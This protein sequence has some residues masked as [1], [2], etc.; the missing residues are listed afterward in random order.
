MKVCKNA[1][2]RNGLRK[3]ISVL[4]CAVLCCASVP[5]AMATNEAAQDVYTVQEVRFC[6]QNGEL[7]VA[8]RIRLGERPASV[9]AYIVL[10]TEVRMPSESNYLYP[11]DEYG[12]FAFPAAVASE[13]G[14]ITSRYDLYVVD[15]EFPPPN[16]YNEIRLNSAS[17]T[18]FDLSGRDMAQIT[19]EAIELSAYMSDRQPPTG[20]PEATETP[21]VEVTEAPTAEATETPV[22]EVTEAPTAEATEAP[23]A[24]PTE[25]PTAVPTEAPTAVP[26][27]APTAEPTEAPTAVPTE[28]PTAEPTE[29]PT[30]VSTEAPTAVPTEAPTAEPTEAPT[31]EPTEAPTAEPTEEPAPT[32]VP[33]LEDEALGYV[34]QLVEAELNAADTGASGS[35]IDDLLVGWVLH[36]ARV[37]RTDAG[38]QAVML[39]PDFAGSKATLPV[40]ASEDALPFLQ[41]WQG[42][43][44]EAA[45]AMELGSEALTLE[46]PAA[47]EWSDEDR[48]KV[49]TWLWEN[50]GASQWL[51]AEMQA[52]GAYSA[53]SNILFPLPQAELWQVD[54]FVDATQAPRHAEKVPVKEEKYRRFMRGASGE[55][56][57]RAQEA[58]ARQGYY[59]GEIDGKFTSE[60]EKAVKQY[61]KDNDMKAD[62]I[63]NA[64]FQRVLY[65]KDQMI[66]TSLTV[67]DLLKANG[68]AQADLDTWWSV[69]L[70]TLYQIRWEAGETG[71]PVLRYEQIPTSQLFD[72]LKAQLSEQ[73]GKGKLAPDE[74]RIVLP[75]KVREAIAQLTVSEKLEA[76]TNLVNSAVA[77]PE[78]T[79]EALAKPIAS[80]FQSFLSGIKDLQAMLGVE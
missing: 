6:K 46:V 30:A 14:L 41:N 11:A 44:R 3:L 74:V 25:A 4:M 20:V 28:A 67:L 31:A 43:L 79:L 47:G 70:Q 16:D 80:S 34:T 57:T 22:V 1:G 60:M 71:A 51:Q 53:M 58:L 78:E 2:K 13:N 62:G 21:V 39:A 76:H 49:R 15:T 24:T 69:Y 18:V 26:T 52:S 56:V 50:A 40:F 35:G 55:G 42:A 45:S 36:E 66:S 59:D 32:A 29:A 65:E 10:P 73:Q 23:T 8:G 38:Y 27:E 48:A 33:M 68:V 54:R 7:W 5:F 77:K 75:E 9:V 72:G 19:A 61:Q 17:H 37:K 12:Y 64:P 63:I